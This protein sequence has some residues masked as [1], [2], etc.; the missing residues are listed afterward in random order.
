VTAD[1]WRARLA[2]GAALV[3]ASI[4]PR[5]SAAGAW[6]FERRMHVLIVTAT[7]ATI[8]MI[9][10]AVALISFTGAQ[11]PDN[12][13]AT[14]LDTGRPTSTDPGAPTSYA[15]ILPSP[16]PPPSISPTDTPPPPDDEP[17]DPVTGA[18]VE[19]P[20]EP[21]TAEPPPPDT[22]P[23]ATN[24]PDK[25]KDPDEPDDSDTSEDCDE[26]ASLLDLLFGPRC[27]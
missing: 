9:G 21:A 23:G 11:Q 7:V 10:G 20:S 8:A 12:E 14:V 6:L 15:P 1:G 19:P 5:I 27:R 22:A 2:A 4:E 26:E 24:R 16:G 25:P 18:P 17:V 3:V 13:V